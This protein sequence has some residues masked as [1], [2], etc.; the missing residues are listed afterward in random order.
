MVWVDSE[1]GVRA[2]RAALEALRAGVGEGAEA[3]AVESEGALGPG[4]GSR[5]GGV[6]R[7]VG[8]RMRVVGLDCEWRHPRP[9]SLLQIACVDTVRLV[10]LGFRV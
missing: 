5:G 7:K 3:R 1:C 2:C 9:V 4:A 6:G 10:D 8:H